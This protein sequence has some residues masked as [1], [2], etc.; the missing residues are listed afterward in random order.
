[1][2]RIRSLLIIALFFLL[3]SVSTSAQNAANILAQASNKFSNS[4]SISATFSLIDNGRSQSGSIIV[5]GNKF[6]IS[7]PQLST[8]FDG[9]THWSYS[10]N[11]KEVNITTPT[12]DELQQ[13]NPFAIISSFRNN[14]NAKLMSSAKG[15]YKIQLT[16]KKSNQSIK[17]V[18]LTLNSSTYFPSLIIITAKNNTK[19]TIKVKSIKAGV[20]QSASTFTFNA[21][22]YP[23]VEIVDLR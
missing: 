5:A 20:A 7:A 15:T 10:P 21:K 13:I 8:W 9:K 11:I 6:A 22:K 14:F 19:A 18:E 3:N 4:K 16:P 17:N 12:S 2:K 1:M 23:G